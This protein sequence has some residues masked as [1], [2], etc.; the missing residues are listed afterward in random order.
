MTNPSKTK[1]KPKDQRVID[2][3]P[4]QLA[5]IM[6]AAIVR[7]TKAENARNR[8]KKANFALDSSRARSYVMDNDNC[9]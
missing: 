7:Y 9:Q 2:S 3:K 8:D 6:Y 5:K 4:V 1:L